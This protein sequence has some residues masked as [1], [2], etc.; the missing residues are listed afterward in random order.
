M[1]EFTADQARLPAPEPLPQGHHVIVPGPRS[2]PAGPAMDRL[3]S[4]YNGIE[5]VRVYFDGDR[6]VGLGV[7]ALEQGAP[8]RPGIIGRRTDV[9]QDVTVGPDR[10]LTRVRIR[11]KDG[12]LYGIEFTKESPQ[13]GSRQVEIVGHGST[14][15]PP[16]YHAEFGCPYQ[17]NNVPAYEIV[18]FDGGTDNDG[19]L[20]S[21]FVRRWFNTPEG[22][23]TQQRFRDGPLGGEQG[24]TSGSAF[25]SDLEDQS[26]RV[27]MVRCRMDGEGVV[28]IQI[29]TNSGQRPRHGGTTGTE[30]GYSLAPTEWLVGIQG[31]YTTGL[32]RSIVFQVFDSSTNTIKFVGPPGYDTETRGAVYEFSAPRWRDNK[33]SQHIYGLFGQTKDGRLKTIGVYR[34]PLRLP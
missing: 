22:G 7:K 24:L 8:P 32:L 17:D 2:G 31:R 5:Y 1:S 20:R 9:P 29:A 11:F 12:Y 33:P 28:A 21:L 15:T 27:T 23:T 14:S 6:I 16:V 18:S 13:G 4:T 10:I 30:Y 34:Y 19:N 3:G 26:D 25:Y